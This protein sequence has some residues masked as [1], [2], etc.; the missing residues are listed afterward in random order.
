M[1]ARL[2]VCGFVSSL[3]PVL[4]AAQDKQDPR[5]Q[6]MVRVAVQTE[7]DADR[8]DRSRWQ[9]RDLYRNPEGEALYQVI[10][11]DHGAVKKKLQANGKALN[12]AELGQEDQRM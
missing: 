1:R 11:T 9:Y 10:E 12:G 3:L 6:Q 4:L 7:L 2:I 8:A 5:A